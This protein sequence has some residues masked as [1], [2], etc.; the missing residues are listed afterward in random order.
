MNT[1][2]YPTS[3]AFHHKY[4]L[5]HVHALQGHSEWPPSFSAQIVRSFP[6]LNLSVSASAASTPLSGNGL[7]NLELENNNVLVDAAF[8]ILAVIDWDATSATPRAVLHQFPLG[9]LLLVRRF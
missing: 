1:G 3:H 2:P 5:D 8:N 4:P 9:A 6:T 7:A